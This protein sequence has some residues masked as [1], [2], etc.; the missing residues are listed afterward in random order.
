MN[1]RELKSE[2]DNGILRDF[3]IF[4][5]G[6]YFMKR[7]Y[8]E[9]IAKTC[10]CEIEKVDIESADELYKI[11]RYSNQN[12]LFADRKRKVVHIKYYGDAAEFDFPKKS[13]NIIVLDILN[14]RNIKNDNLVKFEQLTKEEIERYIS[15]K[16]KKAKKIIEPAALSEIVTAFQG[17]NSSYLELFLDKLILYTK[18]TTTINRKD[19]ENTMEFIYEIGVF[20]LLNAVKQGDRD[21]FFK[22]VDNLFNSMEMIVFIS[23]AASEIIKIL[24]S[25][26]LDK[27]S[28]GQTGIYSSRYREYKMYFERLGRKKLNSLLNLFYEMDVLIKSSSKSGIQEIFKARMFE[29]FVEK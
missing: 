22:K 17:K 13:Y 24:L 14:C 21:G 8:R 26:Y 10:G 16:L 28:A 1:Q 3:Y 4:C 29:W 5:S 6:D 7:V 11:G 2:L 20:K 19:I 25:G 23:I 27:D 15:Y 18:D 12:S 9:R